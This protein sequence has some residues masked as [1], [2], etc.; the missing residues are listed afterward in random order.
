MS[1]LKGSKTHAN[2]KEAFAGES[3]AN[4]RYLFVP[5]LGAV[6]GGVMIF[7]GVHVWTADTATAAQRAA[8][9]ANLDKLAARKPA[10]VVPGHMAPGAATD[11]SAVAFTRNYLLA[12][13]DEL[14]RAPDAASLKSAMEKRFPD[15]G[16]GVALDIGSKVAKGEMKWG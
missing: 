7:S 9:V 14:A 1:E 13:E 16:M 10:I 6:I 12:F 2:L 4:R 3:M 8:W 5:S 15:L 11:L